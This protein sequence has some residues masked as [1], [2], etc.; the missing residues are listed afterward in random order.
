MIS[1]ISPGGEP[2]F[3]YPFGV[4]RILGLAALVGSLLAGLLL[5]AATPAS[6]EDTATGTGRPVVR[7]GTAVFGSRPVP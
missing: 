4:H 1:V 5:G 6:A 3:G 2:S 7:V